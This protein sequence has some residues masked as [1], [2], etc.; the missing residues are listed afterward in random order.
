MNRQRGMSTL[1]MVLLMLLL[2]SLLLQGLNHQHQSTLAQTRVETES[3]RESARVQAALEW[4]RMQAWAS[5]PGI[6]CREVS[7]FAA[8]VCLRKLSEGR[9]LLIAGG[10]VFRYWLSGEEASGK[11][12][13]SPYGWSDF[14]PLKEAT[15]CQ[16]P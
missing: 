5:E 2:G 12:T 16:L 11:V 13:F 3:L 6:Q 14:C 7:T 15:L 1:A 4:G 9:V 10:Q 8:R